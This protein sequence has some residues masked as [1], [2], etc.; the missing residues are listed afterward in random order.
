MTAAV[1][2][3]LEDVV[4]RL[5]RRCD[6]ALLLLLLVVVLLHQCDGGSAAQQ[7]T[8]HVAAHSRRDVLRLQL[9]EG[10]PGSDLAR[11][12]DPPAVQVGVCIGIAV[13]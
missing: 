6:S 10:P 4:Q 2:L 7:R 8:Q 3:S 12:V 11:I 13:R 5:P 1:W 9:V